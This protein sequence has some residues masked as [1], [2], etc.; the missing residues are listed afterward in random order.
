MKYRQLSTELYEMIEDTHNVTKLVAKVLASKQ[1]SD[2]QI[3]SILDNKTSCNDFDLSFLDTIIERIEIAKV[4][5]EKI[6]V[7]G[8]YDADGIC[9]TTIL[10]DALVRYGCDC[11]FYIPNRFSEGYGVNVHT[12]KQAIDKGYKVLITVDNGV[13]AKAALRLAKEHGITV[14]LSDHHAYHESDIVADYFLHSSLLP[15]YYQRL[16]GAGLAYIVSRRLLGNYEYHTVLAGIATLAD[17]VGVLDANRV[18]IKEAIQ[19]LKTKDFDTIEQLR[20][21]ND[22]WNQ[23]KIAFQIV[24][25]INSIGRLADL[26]NANNFVRYLLLE[27][28][29]EIAQMAGKLR[30]LNERRKVISSENEAYAF[31]IVD[32]TQ[33]FIV[34][35]SEHFHEGLNGIVA[36]KLMNTYKRAALV[37]S[38]RDGVLKGSIRSINVDL[39]NL[40]DHF[41][42]KLLA[43]GGHK[44]AAGIALD[45]ASL[46]DLISYLQTIE[47]MEHVG[48]CI[49]IETDDLVVEEIE[50]LASLEPYGVDFTSPIFEIEDHVKFSKIGSGKHLKATGIISY[51][52]FH[53][54]NEYTHFNRN[55]YH[56][57]GTLE[58]NQF[59]NTKSISMFVSDVLE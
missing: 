27:D 49:P 7:C 59:R 55:Q 35:A 33:S 25:K 18:I 42:G 41:N 15:S 30:S 9:A 57:Y 51:L 40:F 5:K 46:P 2:T 34:V 37:L 13:K 52:M 39:T 19:L 6:I 12:V 43:Y 31:S 22:P 45:E 24:P 56:F 8:D 3:A 4:N 11:G 16:S 53:R 44:Q 50:S 17:M 20:D 54:G 1:L 36:A 58:I 28:A 14:I 38:K 29:V 21:N 26:A 32:D 48:T 47:E 10:Y 23:T